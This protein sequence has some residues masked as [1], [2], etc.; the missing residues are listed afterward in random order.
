M[1]NPTFDV[2]RVR[3]TPPRF[4]GRLSARKVARSYSPREETSMFT[5]EAVVLLKKAVNVGC[6]RI[7]LFLNGLVLRGFEQFEQCC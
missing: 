4:L 3:G 6:G 7:E 1:R 2:I 5:V